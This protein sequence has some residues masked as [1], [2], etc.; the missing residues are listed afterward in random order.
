RDYILYKLFME[1][2]KACDDYSGGGDPY[3]YWN[4]DV[5][6]YTIPDLDLNSYNGTRDHDDGGTTSYNENDGFQ[7]VW[8]R[9]LPFDVLEVGSMANMIS[10]ISTLAEET[11]EDD[12][13]ANANAWMIEYDYCIDEWVSNNGLTTQDSLNII[14][15]LKTDLIEICQLGCALAT[16]I[17]SSDGDG[18]TKFN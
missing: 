4:P 8:P 6:D 18:A 5:I 3:I 10:N 13:D 12:C 16:P 17:G 15:E 2:D 1:Y 9:V 14:A 11:C 7:L